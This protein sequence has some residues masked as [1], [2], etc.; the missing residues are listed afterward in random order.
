MIEYV[1]MI[2]ET[3][4][5]TRLDMNDF[6]PIVLFVYNR[7]WH[8]Q[9][10]IEALQKNQLALHSDLYIYSDAAKTE[11]DQS[12]VLEVRQYIQS[13]DGF[14][15]VTVIERNRNYGLADSIMDGV[16]TVVEKYGKIIVLEDDLLTS[17]YFLKYMN[18]ALYIYRDDEKVMSISAYM[19]PIKATLPDT[20]FTYFTSCWGWGTWKNA[21]SHFERNPLGL[22]HSMKR[23][24]IHKFNINGSDDLWRQV[25]LNVKGK[26]FTWAVFWYATVFKRG[27]LVL[28]PSI[29]LTMNIGHDGTGV[30]CGSTLSYEPVMRDTPIEYFEREINNNEEAVST[31]AQFLKLNKISLWSR[32]QNKMR[33]IWKKV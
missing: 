23:N 28:H 21:W 18:E 30:H 29:S 4:D 1:P 5:C 16:T 20:F 12:K 32:V 11:A 17:P 27:G 19:Y 26:I 25:K 22:L 24:E 13:I 6:A 7:P 15:T 9:K 3:I 2:E 8:T 31:I 33:K 10:T 14:K